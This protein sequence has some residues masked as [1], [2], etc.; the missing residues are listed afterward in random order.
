MRIED[1]AGQWASVVIHDGVMP[2]NRGNLD[3]VTL[4]LRDLGG[5]GHVV[6]ECF[7]A[8]WSCYFGAIGGGTLRRFVVL[9]IQV[10]QTM[11]ACDPPVLGGYTNPEDTPW[12]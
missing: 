3:P 5:R 9:S 11:N 1:T 12:Q 8:A 10:L 4:H 7:G 6:V 2:P